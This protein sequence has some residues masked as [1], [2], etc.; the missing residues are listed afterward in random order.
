MH[1]V[2]TEQRDDD[3]DLADLLGRLRAMLVQGVGAGREVEASLEPV[4]L[5]GNRATALALVF[6]ELL[7]N[8]LEH[9]GNARRGRAAR[10]GTARRVLA[11]ADDGA[12]FEEDAAVGTGLSIVRALVR[13]ELRGTLDLRRRGGTRAEVRLPARRA[14]AS[15]RA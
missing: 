9:G 4:L 2:L 1:E 8:A 13:D 11:I 3:V 14:G 15:R 12:G 6:S 5:A 10:S 7:G